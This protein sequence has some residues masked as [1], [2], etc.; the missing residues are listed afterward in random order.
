MAESEG[1]ATVQA[2]QEPKELRTAM[3]MI[4]Q[5][6]QRRKA[7][8]V[9]EVAEGLSVSSKPIYRMALESSLA[10]LRVR[11]SLR[12]DPADVADWMKKQKPI[13]KGQRA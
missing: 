11:G 13:R 1:A 7:M 3:N 4:D 2:N 10:V 9:N 12:F 5:L 6:E 8:T